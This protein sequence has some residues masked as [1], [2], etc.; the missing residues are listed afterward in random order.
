V[1]KKRNYKTSPKASL[2][3]IG[4][5]FIWSFWALFLVVII[6]GGILLG[7]FTPTEAAIVAVVYALILGL[8]YK[9]IT[10]REVPGVI[11]ETLGTSVGVLYILAA[12]TM[13][14]W[15]LT[16]EQIPQSI[17]S[18]LI[19]FT[20]NALI[21]MLIIMAILLFIG[22]FMDITPA[23]VIMTPILLPAVQAVGVDTVWFGVIMIL[24]LLVGLITPPVGMVLFVLSSISECSIGKIAKAIIPYIFAAMVII[25]LII[26]YTYLLVLYPGLPKLY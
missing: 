10:L 23:I 3:E 20:D 7:V 8:V 13:F 17:A 14:S 15:I 9:S 2:K 11:K 5:C 12:A 19:S 16:Y 21:L 24:C 4:K 25:L 1:C 26:L 6:R 18:Y 22:L